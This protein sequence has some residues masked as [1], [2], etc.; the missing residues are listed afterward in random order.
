MFGFFYPGQLMQ[1]KSLNM[2]SSGLDSYHGAQR[3]SAFTEVAVQYF[4]LSNTK[5]RTLHCQINYCMD[6]PQFIHTFAD[7][8]CL[9][10]LA[11]MSNSFSRYFGMNVCF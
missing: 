6:L 8:D 4:I 2:Q 10:F 1:V 11:V 9:C 5:F 3:C 7:T